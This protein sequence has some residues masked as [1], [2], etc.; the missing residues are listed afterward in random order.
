MSNDITHILRD[1][2]YESGNQIR[3]IVAD[4]GREVLQ[5]RQPLGIEQYEL[6][7]R[8]DGE[9]PFGRESVL[10][11][12]LFRLDK[13]RAEH[14]SEEGFSITHDDFIL[15]QNE[16]IIYYFRYLVLFQVGDFVRTARDTEHNLKICDI[17]EDFAESE[18]DKKEILQYRP[19]ILR[20]NA[21]SRAMMSLRHEMRKTAIE[22]LEWAIEEIESMPEIDT[23]AFQFERVRSIN[24]LKSTL[25]QVRDE[26]A[27][28]LGKLREEL[29]KAVSEENYERAAEIRDRIR[30][31]EMGRHPG[32]ES[33]GED[34]PGKNN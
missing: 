26:E 34:A 23:P 28:P 13:Y 27:S 10:D 19:Y 24:Y 31:L 12:M 22:I 9:R 2:K 32:G 33:L 16:G 5:V 17:V 14:G 18:E 29:E 7:G 15:L 6:D 30:E 21:I 3:I 8:P 1:W 20:I 25:K 4:D 11:E